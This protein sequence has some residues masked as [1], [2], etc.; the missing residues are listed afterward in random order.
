M[1]NIILYKLQLKYYNSNMFRPT[2]GYLQGLYNLKMRRRGM[3]HFKVVMFNRKLCVTILCILLVLLCIIIIYSMYMN[4]IKPFQILAPQH[5]KCCPHTR[6][7]VY[8]STGFPITFCNGS[9]PPF[10]IFVLH[11]AVI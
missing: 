1:N 7:H 2:S 10:F 6:L 5:F 11:V 9:D 4:S 3:K 8:V